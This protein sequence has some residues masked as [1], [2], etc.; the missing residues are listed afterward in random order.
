MENKIINTFKKAAAVVACSA[1]V[2]GSGIISGSSVSANAANAKMEKAINWAIAIANDN[3]HGYSQINRNGNPDYDCSSLV[4]NAMK[5][6]GINVGS[7][8]Y[9][10]N[11]KAEFTAHDFVWIPW[12]Q[13]GSTANL[14]RGDVLLRRSNGSGHTELYLGNNKNVGAHSDYDGRGG[15]SSGREINVA[16][17]YYGNWQGVLRY[18]PIA[19]EV[20]VD[21]P[22]SGTFY[23]KC[24]SQYTSIVDALN[25]IGVDSSYSNRSKIAAAN[26]ISGYS[27][28]PAQNTTMLNL[29]K[30]GS[31]RKPGSTTT[32]QYFPKCGSQY[33]S[34]VDALVSIGVDSSYSYRSKI[35]AANGISGYSGTPAQNTNMLNL[36]KAGSL[37]KPA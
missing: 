21:I 6:A 22:V 32:V 13:I 3:S 28:T 25:S 11:M 23:P 10:G 29:L 12:S 5:Y 17:Y 7:A 9:T 15:D 27:G 14:K 33:N 20:I 37:R 24:G 1:L 2:A 30:A 36:L 35:A 26:N 31:L 18:K 16:S 19:N 4:I 8:S 34:I